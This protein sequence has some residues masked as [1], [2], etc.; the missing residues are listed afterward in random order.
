MFVK[1]FISFVILFNVS[2]ASIIR[3]I[4]TETVLMSFI[5]PFLNIENINEKEWK[6][7]INHDDNINAFVTVNKHI[8]INTGLLEHIDDINVIMA[9]LAH[10]SAHIIN[11]DI[12][13]LKVKKKSNSFIGLSTAVAAIVAGGNTD[14][15][16][17]TLGLSSQV[18]Q[19]LNFREI[20]IIEHAADKKSFE[21]YQKLGYNPI[22]IVNA[23]K[24]LISKY[25]ASTGNSYTFTHSTNV[26]RYETSSYWVKNSKNKKYKKFLKKFIN[27][28]DVI[29][30]KYIGYF[31]T[32]E[33]IKYLLKNAHPD[34]I[35]YAMAHYYH[36]NDY[37]IKS[38][39]ILFSL[40]DNKKFNNGFIFEA[41][42]HNFSRLKNN[43]SAVDNC[44]KAREI[45]Y[46]AS[47]NQQ[48]ALLYSKYD[49][50]KAIDLL[51]KTLIFEN[52]RISTYH[53]M[54]KI[55]L[56]VKDNKNVYWAKMNKAHLMGLGNDA[57]RYAKILLNS[58]PKGSKKWQEANI[59]YNIN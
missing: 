40:I 11:D 45:I 29:R 24:F 17:A 7:L 44:E 14:V 49:F 28:Y 34:Y 58:L 20:R 33:R 30:A 55:Y 3:D 2:N 6:L 48:C 1:I 54:E 32:K 4:E 42:S 36:A 51:Q 47:I 53:V 46:N 57:K 5:K 25:G 18:S 10:E 23:Q 52:D 39:N 8:I 26:E 56:H 9:I 35:K 21:L 16:V 38:N 27:A 59:I 50:K 19:R 13:K 22:G 12:S 43:N 37:F 41:I 31:N 15:A